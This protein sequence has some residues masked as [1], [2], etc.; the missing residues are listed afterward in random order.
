[1]A[2]RIFAKR[3]GVPLFWSYEEL[4]ARSG[5]HAVICREKGVAN[6]LLVKTIYFRLIDDIRAERG[7]KR[8][9]AP[10]VVSLSEYQESGLDVSDERDLGLEIEVAEIYEKAKSGFLPV[11]QEIIDAVIKER[12]TQAEA[13]RLFR[14]SPLLVGLVIRRFKAQFRKEWTNANKDAD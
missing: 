11:H 4:R 10:R 5:Y 13:A 8:K 3:Y 2:A 9:R 6:N 1:M 7:L 12:Q 14:R